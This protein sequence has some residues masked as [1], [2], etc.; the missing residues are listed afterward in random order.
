LLTVNDLR[1]RFGGLWAVDGVSLALAGGTILGLIGPNGSGKTTLLNLLNG[2]HRP[3][4]GT[5]WLDQV[6]VAGRS[7]DR[8]ARLGVARTFQAPRVFETLTVGENMLLPTLPRGEDRGPAETRARELLDEV[9]LGAMWSRVAS[10]LSGGQK[11]LLEFAR[12]R[13]GRA[14]LVLMDEPFAGV[15]PEIVAAMVRQTRAMAGDGVAILVVS[16]EIP[17]LMHLVDRVICMSNG[18][19]IAEGD[20]AAVQDD[21]RVVEAYLG[22]PHQGAER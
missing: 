11:K 9:S 5:I 6:S 18:R 13:M 7:P 10:E 17:T 20:P 1:K 4:G 3:D 21:D 19:V 8:M 15:H 22:K 12:S 14:R 16:H 2:V